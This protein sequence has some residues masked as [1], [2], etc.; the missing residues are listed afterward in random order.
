MTA[1]NDGPVRRTFLKQMAAAAGAAPLAPP[2]FGVAA[3]SLAAWGVVANVMSLHFAWQGGPAI[4]AALVALAV[5]LLFGL[6]GTFAALG[7]KPAA[8]L[9]NL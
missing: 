1:N 4:A 5:T 7:R 9:R 6:I 3:G 8:V 2:L